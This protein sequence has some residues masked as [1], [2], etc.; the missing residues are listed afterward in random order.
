[1]FRGMQREV[2][3]SFA[4]RSTHHSKELAVANPTSPLLSSIEDS[5]SG[6]TVV[7]KRSRITIFG[8]LQETHFAK[9]LLV[10]H[11]VNIV[12]HDY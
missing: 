6:P 4:T 3:Y 12:L 8:L 11:D 2:S 10:V 7:E 9:E 1:M 5:K